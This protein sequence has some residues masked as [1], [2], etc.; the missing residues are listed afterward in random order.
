MSG[1]GRSNATRST[2]GQSNGLSVG[3]SAANS[4]RGLSPPAGNELGFDW[5]DPEAAQHSQR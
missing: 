4:N 1:D 5:V 2:A 3:P